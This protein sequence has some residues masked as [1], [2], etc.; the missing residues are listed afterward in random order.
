MIE[1]YRQNK[2]WNRSLP[3]NEKY[4]YEICLGHRRVWANTR[5]TILNYENSDREDYDDE[6][7]KS[8]NYIKLSEKEADEYLKNLDL[9]YFIHYVFEIW[10]NYELEG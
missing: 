6:I 3:R 9:H 7:K 5:N 2:I 1:I 8:K 4:V 10:G